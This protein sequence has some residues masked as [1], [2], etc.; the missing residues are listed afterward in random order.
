MLKA[1]VNGMWKAYNLL[2]L[3]KFH[4]AQSQICQIIA[5]DTELSNHN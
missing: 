2:S 4:G 1:G 3:D 5:N